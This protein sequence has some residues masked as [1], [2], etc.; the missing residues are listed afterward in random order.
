MQN[1]MINIVN[2]FK[3]VASIE[4]PFIKWIY[5]ISQNLVN[6]KNVG[7]QTN[8]LNHVNDSPLKQ[9]KSINKI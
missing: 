8:I 9:V 4:Y 2:V 6:G 1:P 5:C 7:N 3:R